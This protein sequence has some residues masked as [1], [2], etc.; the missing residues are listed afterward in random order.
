MRAQLQLQASNC[1]EEKDLLEELQSQIALL[2]QI[3]TKSPIL[4][5]F[6][7]ILIKIIFA[8]NLSI[9]E[10]ANLR[11]VCRSW[12]RLMQ[13][14]SLWRQVRTNPS[15]HLSIHL[16][17]KMSGYTLTL[18]AINLIGLNDAQ[19][20]NLFEVLSKSSSS[21]AEV[22]L[23]YPFRSQ[24]IFQTALDFV[25]RLPKIKGLSFVDLPSGRDIPFEEVSESIPL[26]VTSDRLERF[27]FKSNF[28]PLV[29]DDA[30]LQTF[31]NIKQLSISY[32]SSSA[33]GEPSNPSLEWLSHF[34]EISSSDLEVLCLPIIS[35]EVGNESEEVQD[36]LES[37]IEFPKLKSI[38]LRASNST[39][40]RA[41]QI[42]SRMTF[43]SLENLD[44][45][46]PSK[47]LKYFQSSNLSIL[48]LKNLS[49]AE[50]SQDVGLFISNFPNLTELNMD[51]ESQGP[52]SLDSMFQF[53]TPKPS[54]PLL[55]NQLKIIR[56]YNQAA[57]KAFSLPAFLISRILAQQCQ[58]E[59]EFKRRL[60]ESQLYEKGC[61]LSTL[62]SKQ[63]KLVLREMKQL[64]LKEG[65]KGFLSRRKSNADSWD[66]IGEEIEIIERFEMVDC[67]EIGNYIRKWIGDLVENCRFVK[68]K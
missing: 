66:G 16:A 58:D 33:L 31:R 36:R 9:N 39:W 7:E 3:R 45:H 53:L 52:S 26:K 63:M 67:D 34:L 57:F 12:H 20:I 6:P 1:Q 49:A 60:E 62:S 22:H 64:I 32:G 8:S 21:L 35:E 27:R 28:Q 14:Q 25:E 48:T 15:E 29:F 61:Q 44:L 59:D 17:S 4:E 50:T 38:T 40:A 43:S 10:L 19:Y 68:S 51:Q 46:S 37:I 18:L 47:V 5:I 30:L 13:T 42:L 11:L 24:K 41:E 54:E 2:H 65:E 23:I 56:I 55:C